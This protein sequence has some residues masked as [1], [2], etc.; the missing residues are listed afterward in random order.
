MEYVFLYIF[1]IAIIIAT[2][3]VFEPKLDKTKEGDI[4]LYY[5]K[6]HKR[7]YIFLYKNKKL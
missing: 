1:L 3:T 2:L 7:E 4:L 6:N 5:N